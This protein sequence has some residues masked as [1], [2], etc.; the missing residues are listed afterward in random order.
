MAKKL[1]ADG[2]TGDV[3]VYQ[4]DDDVRVNP[5]ARLQD[6]FF[7]SALDYMTVVQVM[8]GTLTL[9]A[10]RADPADDSVAYGDAI[11]TIGTHGLGYTPMVLGWIE[12]MNRPLAGDTLIFS[13]GQASLRSLV[14]GADSQRVLIRERYLHKDVSAPMQHIQYRIWI[15]EEVAASV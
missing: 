8:A 10:R 12:N 6:V 1:F 4:G 11:Y 14:L 15:F 2:I 5:F 13:G 9:P 7:H 3:V